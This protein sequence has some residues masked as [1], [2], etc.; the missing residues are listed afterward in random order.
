ME[1]G[2]EITRTAQESVVST[3][4][5]GATVNIT[6]SVGIPLIVMLL[7]DSFDNITRGLLGNNNDDSSDDYTFQNGSVLST[8]NTSD[9]DIHQFG[10]SC[11]YLLI[12]P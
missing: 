9:S 8:V 11:E 10:Q 1:H 3:F 2:V 4:S 12:G 7:P 5:N 6:A